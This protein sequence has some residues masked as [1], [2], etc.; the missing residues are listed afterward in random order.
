MINLRD[1]KII[2][3]PT[4]S[5]TAYGSPSSTELPALTAMVMSDVAALQTRAKEQTGK[6][7]RIYC[8]SSQMDLCVALQVHGL[9]GLCN[10]C[11]NLCI[12]WDLWIHYRL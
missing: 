11:E 4:K 9:S 8:G 6:F 12:D 7:L 1:P 5:G 10:G 3:Y 2:G